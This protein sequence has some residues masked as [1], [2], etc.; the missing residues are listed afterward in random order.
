MALI[1]ESW[2]S[3]L[4]LE[5]EDEPGTVKDLLGGLEAFIFSNSDKLKR[6]SASI[7]KALKTAFD[8]EEEGDNESVNEL[9]MTIVEFLDSVVENGLMG[10]IKEMGKSTAMDILKTIANNE[11]IRNAVIKLV[12][13]KSIKFFVDAVLPQAAMILKAA[14]W[15]MKVFDVSSD[16]KQAYKEGTADV[17]DVFK[18]I[19]QDIM[20]AEDNKE[21][22]SGFFGIL[23][24]DDEWQKMLDDKVEMAFVNNS[25]EYLRSLPPETSLEQINLNQRLIDFLKEK[26]E[27]RS[28][29]K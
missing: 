9:V 25:I 2:R 4:I 19:M 20:T 1:M 10:T 21:T 5:Q 17:N 26:F 16:L 24:I 29:T 7:S 23:N 14:K 22:T 27:G 12:G 18:N 6:V 8:V 11:Q 15:I 13:E 28:V 3:S